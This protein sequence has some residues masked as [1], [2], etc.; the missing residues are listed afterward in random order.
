MKVIHII[1]WLDSTIQHS[2]KIKN[3]LSLKMSGTIKDLHERSNSTD[4]AA[5]ENVSK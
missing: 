3:Y 1:F 4:E 5:P 2:Q